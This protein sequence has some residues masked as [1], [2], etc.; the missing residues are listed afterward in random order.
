MK[1]HHKK[2]CAQCNSSKNLKW[3]VPSYWDNSN[4]SYQPI[5]DDCQNKCKFTGIEP[6]NSMEYKIKKAVTNDEKRLRAVE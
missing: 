1:Y 6:I 4:P 5:C 3:W 2:R